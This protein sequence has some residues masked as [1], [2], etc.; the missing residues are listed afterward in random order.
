[1]A[2][3]TQLKALRLVECMVKDGVKDDDKDSFK[4]TGLGNDIGALPGLTRLQSVSMLGRGHV[5]LQ[6]FVNMQQV[7]SYAGALAFCLSMVWGCCRCLK[8]HAECSS[9]AQQ[10]HP[11]VQGSMH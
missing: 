1:M 9:C 7:P 4:C 8:S 3:L 11:R 5:E 2:A 10:V 6:G